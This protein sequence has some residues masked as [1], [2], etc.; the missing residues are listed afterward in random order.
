MLNTLWV[1]AFEIGKDFASRVQLGNLGVPHVFILPISCQ[2]TQFGTL[3]GFSRLPMNRWYC[4]RWWKL[5]VQYLFFKS[6]QTSQTN[7]SWKTF[8]H[9]K[10][11]SNINTGLVFRHKKCHIIHHIITEGELLHNGRSNSYVEIS[12][13]VEENFLVLGSRKSSSSLR[14]PHV[15][16]PI[17]NSF[18]GSCNNR[19]LRSSAVRSASASCI[20]SALRNL[21]SRMV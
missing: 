18:S 16:L 2:Q 17:P 12:N 21:P 1:S 19:S 8:Y 7:S 4:R 3:C 14:Y 6:I 11:S 5:I 20:A 15:V 10:H 13:S 9:S